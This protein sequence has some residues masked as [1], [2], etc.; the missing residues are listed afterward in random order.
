MMKKTKGLSTIVAT[1]IIILLVLVAVG[2]IWVV[3]RNVI[4]EGASEIKSSNDCLAVEVK[5]TKVLCTPTA[6]GGN[7]GTCNVTYTRSAGGNEIGGIKLVITNDAGDTNLI[8][9]V[10]SIAGNEINPLVTL[11]ETGIVTGIVN[12]S[13]VE[14]TVYFLDES[15][16]EQLCSASTSLN[17]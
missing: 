2:I 3:V 7:N 12:A 5:P 11:T 15:G 17:F 14:V 13:N 9:G 8:H 6:D 4:T 1:L 10:P 16:N